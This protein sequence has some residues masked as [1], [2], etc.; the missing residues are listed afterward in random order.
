MMNPS[1]DRECSG[2]KWLLVSAAVVHEPQREDSKLLMS[3]SDFDMIHPKEPVHGVGVVGH[4]S[5]SSVKACAGVA[6][7]RL[8]LQG[9]GCANSID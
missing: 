9:D 2:S 1:A 7:D 6:L 8:T 5:A 3:A 4:S